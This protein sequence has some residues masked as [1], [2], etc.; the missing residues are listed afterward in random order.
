MQ[1][2]S[3]ASSSLGNL[4]AVTADGLAPLAIECGLRMGEIR[5]C[6]PVSELAGV[7]ISHA[8]ADHSRAAA[9]LM[10]S[11]VDIYASP[12]TWAGL[13]LEG[14]RAHTLLPMEPASIGDWRV[15]PF[16]LRH[17]A[18]GCLGFLVEPVDPALEGRLLYACDTCYVPVRAD[19]ITVLAI[20]CNHS[21]FLLR[22]SSRPSEQKIR[23]LKNHMSLER[24][25]EMLAAND[26]SRVREIWLL[27]LSDDH[28][29]EE[30]FVSEVE[31]ATGKPVYAAPRIGGAA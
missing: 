20:E 24:V 17:D 31:R 11:G 28:S 3:Y 16:E 29:D 2:H 18:D 27:H 7:L 14:H 19:G 12:E 23:A 4:Y 9:K 30:A 25:L 1:F 8:H 5:R 13:D 15:L 21:A 10:H 22:S 26:L 6:L